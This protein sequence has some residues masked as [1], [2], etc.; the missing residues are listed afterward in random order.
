MFQPRESNRKKADLGIDPD[1]TLSNG[2]DADLERL[3]ERH[4]ELMGHMKQ[5]MELQAEERFQMQVDD[6]YHHHLQW[7][8][9]D[10]QVLINRGQ[11]PLVFNEGRLS[12]EWVCGTEKRN[13]IDYKVL[14]RSPEDE[15]PAE[16]ATKVVKYTDDVNLV[17]FHRSAAFRQAVVSG[18]G[19]LEEGI[20][21]EPGEELV[22]AG[23]VDWRDVIRD[24]RSRN[25][26]YNKDG[27][28]LF[29]KRKLDLDYACALLPDAK[30]ILKRGSTTS[31][32][33][34]IESR[35]YLGERLTSAHD[36][37]Y[38]E[39]MPSSTFGDR[40]A[41][42]GTGYA[43]GGRRSAV[44]LIECWYK[45]P[46]YVEVFN[47]G[48][49]DGETFDQTN[50]QHVQAKESGWPL[51]KTVRWRMRVMICTDQA[52]IWDGPSPFKHNRFNLVPVWGFRR[53]RDGMA[54]GLWRGMRDPQ[55]DLN[56]RM[57]K[58]L[59]AA[60]SNRVI[61]DED[62]VEDIEEARQEIARPDGWVTK[63]AGK[64]LREVQNT[65]DVAQSLNLADRDREHLRN[66][67]G[68]TNENLGRDT[69]AT[70]GKA[71]MAKQDQGST[72][73]AE[74]FDNLRLATQIAGQLRLSNIQQ[75]MSAPK[76][77][78]IVGRNRPVEWLK[79]NQYDPETGEYLND[80]TSAQLDFIVDEQNWRANMQ[81][82]AL[83]Q[84]MEML[85]IV[86]PTAPQAVINLL[87]ILVEQF[88]IPD[89]AEVV[90]RI[91]QFNGQ[92][93]PSRKPTPEE[94][95]AMKKQAEK[96]ELQ[97]QLQT[98]QVMAALAEIK[99]KVAKIEADSVNTLTTAFYQALQAGQIVAQV[100]GVA[101][102]ADQIVKGAGFKDQGGQ[103]PNLQAPAEPMPVQPAA[104]VE[105][106]PELQQA[107]GA[108]QGIET[109]TP[110][111]VM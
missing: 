71:I 56:K 38:S 10:A 96:A 89:K 16:V 81:Q 74:L 69:N 52:P 14:P 63:K 49:L 43:D 110:D 76:V 100:P 66:A 53:G 65:A 47:R 41:Y 32:L 9:R 87:D 86:G 80:I 106:A 60:S 59:W 92:R 2:K 98:E 72:T 83:E 26:D 5:E 64:D 105:V 82:A 109:P 29:R 108:M 24:S 17:R 34:D 85:K 31:N 99:A 97:E 3:Q 61:A 95:A 11:V 1:E 7:D 46:E 4:G 90:A 8:P 13:R 19:W 12:V 6:D 45:V 67:S 36:L 102:V 73:T 68:V 20:N 23:S 30:E 50:Q 18:L 84:F 57:S 88:D 48:E 33:D 35:W 107:D 42:V 77:I 37:D 39:A 103:D 79:V 91:R 75:F 104:P 70:S 21:I 62:A 94:E 44:D 78:R 15:E 22:F 111:G 54:Y 28:Y 25:P 58:A 55:Y 51:L 93:D 101:P 40:A 27:R